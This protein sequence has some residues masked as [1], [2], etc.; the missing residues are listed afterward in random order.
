MIK[1]NHLMWAKLEN[2]ERLAKSLK[3]AIPP[4]NDEYTKQLVLAYK[5]LKALEEPIDVQFS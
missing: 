3:I 4:L 1:I 5:I 2:L